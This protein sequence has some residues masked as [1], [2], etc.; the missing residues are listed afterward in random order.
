VISQLLHYLALV[1]IAWAFWQVFSLIVPDRPRP[2]DE[3]HKP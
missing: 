1:P 2:K 3:D